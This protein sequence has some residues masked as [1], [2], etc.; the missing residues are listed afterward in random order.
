MNTPSRTRAPVGPRL[1]VPTHC[2]C[3]APGA[4]AAGGQLGH[5]QGRGGYK[6]AGGGCGTGVSDVIVLR[7]RASQITKLSRIFEFLLD[8][9]ARM[10]PQV[11]GTAGDV[12]V[13]GKS[14]TKVKK[15][16]F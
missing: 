3:Q 14:D 15:A 12:G 8:F 7:A 6:A 1:V 13:I 4:W 16:Q 11:R 10:Y 5:G 9:T 2:L